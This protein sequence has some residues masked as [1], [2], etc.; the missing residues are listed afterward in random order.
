MKLDKDDEHYRLMY[1]WVD[2]LEFIEGYH[3]LKAK[4]DG[5]DAFTHMHMEIKN[6]GWDITLRIDANGVMIN[7]GC[8]C[9]SS[10]EMDYYQVCKIQRDLNK[11]IQR[12]EIQGENPFE[13]MYAPP[14][15]WTNNDI[16]DLWDQ[17]KNITNDNEERRLDRDLRRLTGSIDRIFDKIDRLTEDKRE[18]YLEKLKEVLGKSD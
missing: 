11:M 1:D 4:Q 15:N 12:A 2:E 14:Q 6:A 18:Q 16:N 5:T 3:F 13:G 7:C 8:G 9:M 10:D 17:F